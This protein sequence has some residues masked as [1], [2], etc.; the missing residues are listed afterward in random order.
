MRGILGGT[1]Y[2]KKNWQIPKYCVENRQSTDTA[3]RSLGEEFQVAGTKCA[4]EQYHNTVKDLLLP[5]TVSQKD[6]K[7]YTAGLD[8]TTMRHVKIEITEI[9]VHGCI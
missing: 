3:F 2:H 7:M 9:P 1:Q 8:D 6:E 5:N 4:N